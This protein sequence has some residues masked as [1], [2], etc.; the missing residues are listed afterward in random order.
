MSGPPSQSILVTSHRL[1]LFWQAKA[2]RGGVSWRQVRLGARKSL[3]ERP[4]GNQRKHGTRVCIMENRSLIV[5]PLACVNDYA[6]PSHRI[7]K[8]RAR[9]CVLL[10]G[11]VRALTHRRHQV[12][13]GGAAQ[14]SCR[15][16]A[17]C[18]REHREHQE[19][20]LPEWEGTPA[21]MAAA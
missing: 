15:V 20:F 10:R 7:D 2:K 3:H 6:L 12:G 1:R 17:Q 16:R 9:A 11:H 19:S 13:G 14:I 21:L 8:E 5:P 4:C 18:R